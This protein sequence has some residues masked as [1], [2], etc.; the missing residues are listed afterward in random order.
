MVF[1]ASVQ[2]DRDSPIPL[3]YQLAQG[4]L[5]DRLGG[6]DSRRRLPSEPALCIN[7]TSHVRRCAR[8]SNS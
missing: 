2:I 3:Y 7:S 8:P 1:D 4:L 6:L 5:R